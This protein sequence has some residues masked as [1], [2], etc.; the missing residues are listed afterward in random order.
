MRIQIAP[1]QVVTVSPPGQLP[2]A[3][4]DLLKATDYG[5]WALGILSQY[6]PTLRLTATGAPASY[7]PQTSLVLVNTSLQPA[8]VA[9]YLTHEM[10]HVQRDKTGASGN[11]KTMAKQQYVDT[12][13]SEE[14][15]GTVYGY[16][17][18]FELDQN[19]KVPPS[20]P[21]PD[22]YYDF[23]SAYLHARESKIKDDPSANYTQIR[24]YALGIGE[25]VMRF[26]IVQ[27]RDPG[28]NALESY[29]EYYAR[30][31]E[32]MNRPVTPRP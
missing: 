25:K 30:D 11:P 10:Y 8:V 31:W 29:P 1:F 20:C 26:W 6:A 17:V 15:K 14:I 24:D 19:G 16:H 9:S 13:V 5:V 27:Q 4:V 12:M 22:H 2:Q 18:F 3:V 32:R 28:A 23:K 21:R 7:N